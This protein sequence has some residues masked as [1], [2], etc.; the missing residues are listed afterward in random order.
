MAIAH[1]VTVARG[2]RTRALLHEVL[3][4]TWIGLLVLGVG[5]R[6]VMRAI[7]L[8]TDAPR[9]LTLGG[10]VTVLAAGAA[11]GAAGAVLH[12]VSRAVAA[13]G[14]GGRTVVRLVL[15]AALLALV[16][17]RGLHGSPAAPARAFWPLV[18]LYGVLFARA[19]RARR[20][21]D[22]RVG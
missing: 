10:T 14:A 3:L 15:F 5:G 18:A 19:V 16:T 8:A 1:T 7:A 21:G 20:A 13:R 9:A 6:A 12:A 22:S 11:A 4:G 2:T 17:A